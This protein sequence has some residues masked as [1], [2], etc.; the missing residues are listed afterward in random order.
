M[1]NNHIFSNKT[2]VIMESLSLFMVL[3]VLDSMQSKRRHVIKIL[4]KQIK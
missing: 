4:I 1:F 2:D 3:F